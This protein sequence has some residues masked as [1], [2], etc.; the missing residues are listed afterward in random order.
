MEITQQIK[1]KPTEEQEKTLVNLSEKCR[2]IYNFALKERIEAFE[3]NKEFVGYIKQQNDLPEIK[4]EYP[5]YKWVYSKVLQYVLRILD[6]DYKSFFS[7]R[8]KGDKNA[9]PPKW[10]GKK[11]FTTMVF[12]QSGFGIKDNKVSFS[13][14]HP[15][16]IK[17]DFE[18]PKKFDW[19]NQK[20]IKQINIYKKD[21]DY[22]VSITYENPS[23]KYKDNG[24]YQAF[25]L[26]I[27]KQ[28]AINNQGKFIEFINPRVDKYWDKKEKKIQAKRD[29]YS[30]GKKKKSRKWKLHHKVLCRIK[31]KKSNQIKDYIHKLSNKI[32]NNTKANTIIVGD[33]SVKDMCNNKKTKARR[34]KKIAE[35]K[36]V[37]RKKQEKG[38]HRSQHNTGYISR[39]VSFL[40]Y[41][42]ELLGKRVIEKDEKN[43]SKTCSLCGNIKD[44]LKL[45][46]RDYICD[47]GNNIDRDKNSTINQMCL[48]LSQNVSWTHFQEF[49]GNLEKNQGIVVTKP[50]I[51]NLKEAPY[52]S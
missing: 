29:T 8:K 47:C 38:L 16:G 7:L 50:M 31:R 17:L 23:K 32:V 35:G 51:S 13:H 36:L 24:K 11:H 39:F 15:S 22:Y 40:T 12:N 52:I 18:L 25:D 19:L 44:D 2:L 33:L 45:G 46:D 27:I 30:K 5:E 43:T 4:K 1:I 42:A 26:G 14:K 10:K 3:N 6:A 37:L 34:D 28:T 49:L 20:P 48:Y 41:K 21:N 9:K